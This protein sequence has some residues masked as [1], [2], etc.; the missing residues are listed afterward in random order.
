MSGGNGGLGGAGG[1]VTGSSTCGGGASAGVEGAAGVSFTAGGAAPHGGGGGG[2][3]YVGG[4]QGGGGASD[5]CG[6]AAGA[7]GGG[8]GSSYAA[9]GLS[10]A[11]SAGVRSGNGQASISYSNPVKAIAHKYLTTPDQELAVP[12]ASGVLSGVSPP[13]GVQLSASL[14]TPPA[15]GSLALDADGSFAYT[16][17]PSYSG[18]DSFTYQAA[19]PAGNQASAQVTLTVA[20]PPSASISTPTPGGTYTVGQSVSTGFSCSEGAGGTGLSSCNDSSGV[21]TGSG[22]AGHLDTSTLGAHAYTVTAVSKGGLTGSSSIDYTVVP[23]LQLPDVPKIPPEIPERPPLN[24]SLGIGREPLSKLLR[25]G[26]LVV[27]ARVNAPAKVALLGNAALKVPGRGRGRTRLVT[28]FKGKTVS[29][30]ES[31]ERKVTL[32]LSEKGR[33]ALRGLSK[34]RL[35]IA[36]KA[37]GTAGETMTQTVALTLQP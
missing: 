36:G 17:A 37:T 27:T 18:A 1:G 15:H 35:S 26:E 28:V 25:S 10:A 16:P 7:G 24:L 6:D 19:D 9:P 33:E 34:L 32:V 20:A 22:G 14:V 5:G 4:G 21:K 29:F 2:G 13:S 3:G 31:G 12:A 11:F 23:V 30:I 8:G